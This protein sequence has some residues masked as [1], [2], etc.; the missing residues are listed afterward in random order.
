M[1]IDNLN[2]PNGNQNPQNMET[3]NTNNNLGGM[4]PPPMPNAPQNNG[5]QPVSPQPVSEPTPAPINLQPEGMVMSTPEVQTPVNTQPEPLMG[6]TLT[7]NS[8]LM[9]TPSGANNINMQ[10]TQVLPNNFA[11]PNPVQPGFTPV[12]QPMPMN[13]IQPENPN[14]FGIPNN[15][16]PTPPNM[17]NGF[18][19]PVDPNASK[20]K[21]SKGDKKKVTPLLIVLIVVLIAVV[22]F[23]VYYFL[24]TGKKVA[25]KPVVLIKMVSWEKG[26]VLP[27]DINEYANITGVDPNSC[28]VDKNSLDIN[29]VAMQKIAI[30]CP[31]LS[32]P[33]EGQIEVKD[34]KGPKV[35][36]KDVVVTPN[37]SVSLNDFVT[38]C[39]DASLESGECSVRQKAD[40]VAIEELIKT[41]GEYSLNLETSDDYNNVTSF[42]AKLTVSAEAPE[43]T[44]S[45][46]VTNTGIE[47]TGNE[48]ITVVYEYGITPTNTLYNSKRVITYQYKTKEE[49]DAAVNSLT[50]TDSVV[51][52]EEKAKAIILTKE[53]AKESLPTEFSVESFPET[54]EEIMNFHQSENRQDSCSLS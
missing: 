34:T 14:N 38:T 26:E 3:L 30:S 6:A 36:S 46:E 43:S 25:S 42:T 12:N 32:S 18:T 51:R 2:N 16:V 49:Y 23:A 53:I 52:Y 24:N 13:N 20:G 8:N 41:E 50:D 5:Y 28:T 47:P 54:L 10:Q 11:N 27:T 1:N 45:C 4:T 37:A 22:G 40:D 48:K 9:G 39:T 29:K 15:G 33:V 21:K 17:N 31:G 19:A 7:P 44:L 35:I